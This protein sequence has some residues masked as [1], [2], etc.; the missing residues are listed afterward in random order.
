MK[1]K[2]WIKKNT[3]VFLPSYNINTCTIYRVSIAYN[4]S[5]PSKI[6]GLEFLCLEDNTDLILLNIFK[7]SSFIK[8]LQSMITNL[9]PLT[10]K[11]NNS[12]DKCPE[13][14]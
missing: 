6:Y 10:N 5:I 12:G 8:N 4:C 7:S 2:I 14:T 13:G 11:E 1:F 3:K 9:N